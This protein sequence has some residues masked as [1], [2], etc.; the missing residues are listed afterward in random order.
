MTKKIN[1]KMVPTGKQKKQKKG[2]S[3]FG[4]MANSAPSVRNVVSSTPRGTMLPPKSPQSEK[5]KKRTRWSD[6]PV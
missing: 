3:A 6:T 4:S 5:N 1:K 2:R